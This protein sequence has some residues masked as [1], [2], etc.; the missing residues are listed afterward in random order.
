MPGAYS[1]DLRKKV[2][3]AVDKKELSKGAI[4]KTFNVDRKTIYN[5][6]KQ[7]N[8]TGNLDPVTD[9]YKNRKLKINDF[10]KFKAFI[11]ENQNMTLKQLAQKWGGV[12]SETIRRTLNNLGY[13]FKK[14][15]FCIKKGT[16]NDELNL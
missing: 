15:S 8:R 1:V 11:R 12:S 2:L 9:H 7:R 3:G 13:S 16:K 5:W 6:K 14:N 10:E 4:A